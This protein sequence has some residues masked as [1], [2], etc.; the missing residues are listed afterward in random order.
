[1]K[2]RGV[3]TALHFSVW[4]SEP[5]LISL[6]PPPDAKSPYCTAVPRCG[7]FL[8]VDGSPKKENS[9]CCLGDT[10]QLILPA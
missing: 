5:Y 9:I 7:P 2:K 6:S 3:N 10:C 8:P 1:M 4:L